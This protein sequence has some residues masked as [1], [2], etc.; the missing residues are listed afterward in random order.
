MS[1][2]KTIEHKGIIKEADSKKLIVSIITNSSCAS[3]EAKGSCSASE[4]EEKEIEIRTFDGI[5]KVGEQVVVFLKESLGFR[6]M[7]LG[8]LLPFLVLMTVLI[9]GTSIGLDEGTAG[10]L[11]LGSL[12]PYYMLIFIKNKKLKKT[13]SFSIRKIHTDQILRNAELNF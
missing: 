1:S 10:L 11:A 4:I 9:I 8:Y 2:I 6:A 7:F 3:C 12:V 13:F 5:Y